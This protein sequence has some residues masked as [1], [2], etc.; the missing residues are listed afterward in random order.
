MGS[1]G[2]LLEAFGRAVE[3]IRS[4]V[5]AELFVSD[6]KDESIKSEAGSRCYF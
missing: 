5:L 4:T 1:L 2:V 6:M 3:M